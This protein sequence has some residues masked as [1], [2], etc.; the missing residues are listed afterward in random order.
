MYMIMIIDKKMKKMGKIKKFNE[1]IIEEFVLYKSD[2]DL[3]KS[4]LNASLPLITSFSKDP[5]NLSSSILEMC[6]DHI[7]SQI[8][9]SI[10]VSDGKK[11]K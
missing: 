2:K 7:S 9:E 8:L 6:Y 3:E 1:L 10:K 11:S 5:Y 4:R